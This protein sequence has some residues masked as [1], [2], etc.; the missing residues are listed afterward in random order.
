[1][2]RHFR[3][4]VLREHEPAWPPSR[5]CRDRHDPGG[6]TRGN[7]VTGASLE[8]RGWLS[9]DRPWLRETWQITSQRGGLPA[10][11]Q[12]PRNLEARCPTPN[13][14]QDRRGAKSMHRSDLLLPN[15]EPGEPYVRAR[16]LGTCRHDQGLLLPVAVGGDSITCECLACRASVQVLLIQESFQARA[17]IRKDKH[18]SFELDDE[19]PLAGDED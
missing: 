16:L 10:H 11:N 4:P 14:Q 15:D 8:S 2:E 13:F 7:S 17:A 9:C 1:M 12:S 6:W 5:L 3:L 18:V 19:Y